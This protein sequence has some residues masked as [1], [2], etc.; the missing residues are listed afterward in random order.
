M[1]APGTPGAWSVLITP[2]VRTVLDAMIDSGEAGLHRGLGNYLRALG[3]EAEAAIKAGKRL[4]GIR[5]P[6]SV[7]GNQAYSVDVP[8]EGVFLTYEVVAAA[9]A[10]HITTMIW[11]G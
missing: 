11:T 5:M 3:L 10:F 6:D 4:P 1:T 2:Q 9:Q 8:H 7:Q